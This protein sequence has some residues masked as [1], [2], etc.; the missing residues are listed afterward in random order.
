MKNNIVLLFVLISLKS[1]GQT[2][3]E[4]L[5]FDLSAKKGKLTLSNPKNITTHKGYD[6]QPSFRQEKNGLN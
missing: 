1:F 3:S 2:G 5:L 6:N 4:I